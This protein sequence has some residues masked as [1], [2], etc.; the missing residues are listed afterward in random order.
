MPESQSLS[1]A[2]RN[3]IR[4]RAAKLSLVVGLLICSGKFLAFY[5]TDSSAVLSDALESIVNIVAA[6]LMLVSIIVA[7]QPADE[8]HPYGHG[9]VE[10]VSAG[11][12][13]TLIFL[14]GLLILGQ[15]FHEI[16]VGPHV[17]R[18]GAGLWL[19]AGVT[20]LNAWL[21]WHL[22]RVGRKTHSPALEADGHHLLTDV[23]TSLGVML[24]LG[25]VAVTGLMILDP[26]T[27]IVLAIYILYTGGKLFRE[28]LGGLLD[29]ANPALLQRIT[30]SLEENREPWL[31]GAHSLRV[32]RSGSHYHTDL[33]VEVPR[34]LD[35]DRLHEIHEQLSSQI[36]EATGSSAEAI[37]H[38]DPCRPRQCHGCT[39][40]PC[41]KRAFPLESRNPLSF[42]EVTREDQNLETGA[43]VHSSLE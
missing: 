5:I 15:A 31:I 8:N 25:L 37:V 10:F 27:A 42:S 40:D 20:L 24:G 1:I 29:E 36:S 26:L 34:Y 17:E 38:F 16:W 41:S 35:A 2:Q 14:A 33:H 7:A 6:G 21:G 23:V 32:R 39:M 4:L 3:T 22:I 28:A 9:K 19:V 30:D 11:V 12:E 18:I 43:P 13:G